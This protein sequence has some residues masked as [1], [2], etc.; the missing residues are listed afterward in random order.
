MDKKEDIAA[1]VRMTRAKFDL[2]QK[3]FAKRL[4]VSYISVSNWENGKTTPPRR[5]IDAIKD[6]RE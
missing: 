2:T 4:C 6:M 1:L 3:E 5:K